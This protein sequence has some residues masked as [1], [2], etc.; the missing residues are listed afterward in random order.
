MTPIQ[1]A[2]LH[3][4]EQGTPVSD[5]FD[6]V[7]FSNDN[8]LLETHYVFVMHNGLPARF[9]THPRR[10]FHVMETGFGTGLNFL[11]LWRAFVQH[12]AQHPEQT[13]QQLHFSTFEKYPLSHADLCQ[14]LR[15]WPE[16]ADYSEPLLAQ[17]PRVFLPGCQRLRFLNG[18][19][20]LDLWLGD[21]HDNLPQVPDANRVDAWFLDGFAPSK[22]PDMWQ[23]TLWQ[24]M[25]RLSQPGTSVATFTS[26]GI[27]RRGIAS[28]GFVVKKVKGFGK[29]REMAIAMMPNAHEAVP[30]WWPVKAATMQPELDHA[31]TAQALPTQ[32]E[33]T[34]AEPTQAQSIQAMAQQGAFNDVLPSSQPATI[35]PFAALQDPLDLTSSPLH[36]TIVGGGLA[37]VLLSLALLERGASVHL[38]CAD[39]EIA[40]HA[41]HNRQGALY[42]QLQYRFTPMSQL[43]LHAFLF[44]KRRYTELLQQFDFAHDFCGVLQLACNDQLA[45]RQHKIAQ[46]DEFPAG[47]WQ[48]LTATQ[49]SDVAG[50]TVPYGG[51][52]FEDGGWIAPQHFC[53][54]ALRY[55][56]TQ[57]GFRVTLECQVKDIQPH[58]TLGWQLDTNGGNI[59]AT[60]LVMCVGH[61]LPDWAFASHLP[62]SQVRGQV[63]HVSA[64]GLARLRTVLCHQGYI[65]PYDQVRHIEQACVGASFDR[66]CAEPIVKAADDQFNIDLVNEVLQQ[67]V[68]FGDAKVHSAKAGVRATVRDHVPVIGQID[69]TLFVF[70]GLGARGLLFGP[71]LAEQL[72]AELCQQVRPLSAPLAALADVRRFAG[73]RC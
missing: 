30:S 28:A 20:T 9:A 48:Q 56:Q 21:V 18:R 59:S 31:Q 6:D 5:V 12:L 37:S 68:W 19:I 69:R 15:Q 55:L 23:D 14:A 51:I 70:G 33:L 34:Q 54:Q 26:A 4:N 52:W 29:K 47:V 25:A 35:L 24:G 42:P 50:V 38:V 44:A 60:T 32:A 39:A 46:S 61:A 66:E 45:T 72:A 40:Q 8:G 16:L 27:V 43:H 7:Y 58:A 64:A 65:T 11:V 63:S 53:Q 57:A 1:R 49:A 67:P 10:Q 41:S 71:L 13:C 73:L 62:M 36:I 17:Y 3:Y 2:A 22:N